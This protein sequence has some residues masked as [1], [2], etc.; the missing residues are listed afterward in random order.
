MYYN[1]DQ[2]RFIGPILPFVGGLL[3]GGLVAPSFKTNQ[4]PTPIYYQP[5]QYYPVSTPYPY[6]PYNPNYPNYPYQNKAYSQ[7]NNKTTNNYSNPLYSQNSVNNP[8][9][10]Q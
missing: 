2:T 3:V 5:V 10:P 7:A 6:Y 8:Y 9:Y 4:Q 1:D